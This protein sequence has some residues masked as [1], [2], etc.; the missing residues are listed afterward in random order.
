MNWQKMREYYPH[1]WLLIE[2]IKARSEGGKRII[3]QIAVIN[4]FNDS[5]EAMNDYK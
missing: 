1:Q 4:A 2:A 5:I 3:D